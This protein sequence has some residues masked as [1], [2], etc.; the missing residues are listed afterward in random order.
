[1]MRTT[2]TPWPASTY[3]IWISPTPTFGIREARSRDGDAGADLA[4]HPVAR[5][6]LLED[7][8]VGGAGRDAD[9][10]AG[11]EAA[12]RGRVDRAGHV[13]LQDDALAPH[14]RIGNRHRREQRL[15][16]GVPGIRVELL[17][18][19]DLH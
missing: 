9:R 6:D 7:L 4:G 10:A 14:R 16:V 17:A 1:M 5:R 11:V 12:T 8:I 18:R 19:S 2:G 3:D 13:A 15:G